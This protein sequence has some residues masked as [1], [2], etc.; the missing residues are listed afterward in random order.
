M[1]YAKA[2]QTD[3]FPK[4][5]EAIVIDSIQEFRVKDYITEIAKYTLPTNIRF[6]SND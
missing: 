6:V 3:N 4:K 2:I 1:N 5:E